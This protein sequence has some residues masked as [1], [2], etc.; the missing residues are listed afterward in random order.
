MNPNQ[1]TQNQQQNLYQKLRVAMP[2]NVNTLIANESVADFLKKAQVASLQVGF[3]WVNVHC[4]QEG[5]ILF[6][7]P[8]DSIQLDGYG[9]LDDEKLTI[10]DSLYIKERNLGFKEN[11]QMTSIRRIRYKLDGIDIVMVHYLVVKVPIPVIQTL[12]KEFPTPP[13][14]QAQTIY[15]PPIQASQQPQTILQPPNAQQIQQQQFLLQ[16][17]QQHQQQQRQLQMRQM[18]QQQVQSRVQDEI[19]DGGINN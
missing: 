12:I 2:K 16:Q 3:E 4:L 10:V 17:Q 7:K 11:D 6:Y 19:I 15:Q 5:S 18:H 14:Q 9:W 1:N 8:S 13:P